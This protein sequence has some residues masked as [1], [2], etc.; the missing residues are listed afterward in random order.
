MCVSFLVQ[1]WHSYKMADLGEK[2]HA[3]ITFCFK[4]G[5]DGIEIIKC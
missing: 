3:S 2:N 4:L 5:K 1:F